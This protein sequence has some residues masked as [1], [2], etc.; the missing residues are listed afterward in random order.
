[1][2]A[3]R[4]TGQA[5]AARNF[6]WFLIPAIIG[7]FNAQA[8]AYINLGLNETFGTHQYAGTDGYFIV[9]QE[10]GIYLEP[11]FSTYHSD[12]SNGTYGTYGGRM[13]YDE[14]VFSVGGEVNATPKVAGYQKF[15]TSG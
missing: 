6:I 3:V 8:F 10:K 7:I 13:G 12:I 1:M 2:T 11:K 4:S 15:A 14:G 9:G 5:R